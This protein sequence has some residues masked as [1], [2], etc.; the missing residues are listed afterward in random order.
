M[1]GTFPYRIMEGLPV[2][3]EEHPQLEEFELPFSVFV[4]SPPGEPA[5]QLNRMVS[6]RRPA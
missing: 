3:R 2:T 1:V 6:L 4:V 5:V